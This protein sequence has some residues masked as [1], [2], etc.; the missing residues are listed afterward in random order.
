MTYFWREKKYDYQFKV[1]HQKVG[2]TNSALKVDGKSL[3][4]GFPLNNKIVDVGMFLLHGAASISDLLSDDIKSKCA[5]GSLIGNAEEIE[6]FVRQSYI[7]VSKQVAGA[8]ANAMGQLAQDFVIEKLKILL[9]K[10]KFV[11]NG[12]LLKVVRQVVIR[13]RLLMS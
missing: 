9:P 12:T 11:R 1:I 4:K 2:L 8:T 10:W 5:I 7:R 6:K 13:K 3:L